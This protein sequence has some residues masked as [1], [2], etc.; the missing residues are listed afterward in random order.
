MLLATAAILV[1]T[2]VAL[3]LHNELGTDHV[4][5]GWPESTAVASLLG[6]MGPFIGLQV[7][8]SPNPSSKCF[9]AAMDGYV[10]LRKRLANDHSCYSI[11]FPN[12]IRSFIVTMPSSVPSLLTIG[13]WSTLFRR[14]CA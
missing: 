2:G 1:A 11:D 4:V 13:R 8:L 7:S 5:G 9:S 10:L 3:D 14:M 12:E 6:L